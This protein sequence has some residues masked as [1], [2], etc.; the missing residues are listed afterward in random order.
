MTVITNLA[1]GEKEV[2]E[3]ERYMLGAC[4]EF[5]PMIVS[6]RVY[7]NGILIEKK[8]RPFAWWYRHVTFHGKKVQAE[9]KKINEQVL[10]PAEQSV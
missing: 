2:F 7:S 8:K 3:T 4:K 5:H 6:V 1:N 9:L 10:K